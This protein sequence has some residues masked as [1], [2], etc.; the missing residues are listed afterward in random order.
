MLKRTVSI[1]SNIYR[2]FDYLCSI[3]PNTKVEIKL[4]QQV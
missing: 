2:V 3:T 1:K 4:K